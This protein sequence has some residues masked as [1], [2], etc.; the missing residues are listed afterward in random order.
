MRFQFSAQAQEGRILRFGLCGM[1]LC[2][3]A[4]HHSLGYFATLMDSNS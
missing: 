3:E 2:R 4:G 1:Q